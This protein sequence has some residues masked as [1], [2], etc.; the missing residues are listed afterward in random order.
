VSFEPATVGGEVDAQT[1]AVIVACLGLDL[2]KSA[3]V[4][5][6]FEERGFV[7]V[8]RDRRLANVHANVRADRVVHGTRERLR[9]R[10]RFVPRHDEHHDR[11]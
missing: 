9:H 4:S 8:G 11:E 5:T 1:H 7:R 2:R 10:V 6:S 3:R